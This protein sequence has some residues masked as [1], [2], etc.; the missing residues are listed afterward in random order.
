MLVIRPESVPKLLTRLVAWLLF[1]QWNSVFFQLSQE[2][3][4]TGIIRNILKQFLTNFQ[5]T[6]KLKK[7]T[8]LLWLSSPNN[9]CLIYFIKWFQHGIP[10]ITMH[11]SSKFMSIIIASVKGRQVT[12]REYRPANSHVLCASLTPGN[13][14][15]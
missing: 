13:P 3:N 5:C 4:S 8:E 11:A 9:F 1:Y 7:S 12:E 14:K 6:I 15:Y 10:F 2:F